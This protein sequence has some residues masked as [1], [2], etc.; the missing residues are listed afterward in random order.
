MRRPSM[1]SGDGSGNHRRARGHARP[2]AKRGRGRRSGR[3]GIPSS[4]F[5]ALERRAGRSAGGDGDKGW[6]GGGGRGRTATRREDRDASGG[7]G[8]G[9]RE[10][11]RRRDFARRQTP[12][13][14]FRL[15]P[16]GYYSLPR[17]A[18]HTMLPRSAAAR[19]E[20]EEA[21]R[22]RQHE[23]A[24]PPL[25]SFRLRPPPPPRCPCA[26]RHSDQ[27]RH[28]ALQPHP[29]HRPA[30]TQ[31]RG[32]GREWK[33]GCGPTCKWVPL[34]FLIDRWVRIYFFKF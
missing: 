24:A 8:E 4:P 5:A 9:G 22:R 14:L 7:G 11:R 29:P 16:L 25:L 15:Q 34:F 17:A 20:A 21:P 28:R 19:P 2:S 3:C 27:A 12:P 18:F 32:R 26:C 33:D 10:E 23:R 6:S 1:G 31:Q 30:Q 13:P